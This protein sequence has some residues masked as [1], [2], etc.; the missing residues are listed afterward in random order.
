[1]TFTFNV[2]KEGREGGREGGRARVSPGT[3]VQGIDDGVQLLLR[4]PSFPL[5]DDFGQGRRT[6][7]SNDDGFSRAEYLEGRR[8]G[9][10]MEMKGK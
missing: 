7:K 2:M 9:G 8:E 1:M 10:Y 4:R 5:S 3:E 6:I